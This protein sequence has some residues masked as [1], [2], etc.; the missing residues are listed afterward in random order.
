[1]PIKQLLTFAFLLICS[2]SLDAQVISSSGKSYDVLNEDDSQ[3]HFLFF[4][5]SQKEGSPNIELVDSKIRKGKLKKNF[6]CS[7][8]EHHDD[9]YLEFTLF[10]KNGKSILTEKI[11]DPSIHHIE[12]PEEDMKTMGHLEIESETLEFL[13]RI[14]YHTS[15]ASVQFSKGNDSKNKNRILIPLNKN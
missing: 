6:D 10:D 4:K 5:Y 7:L 12:Y 11:S 1:M 3:I 8:H 2:I 9:E 13:I 14:P 15:Q